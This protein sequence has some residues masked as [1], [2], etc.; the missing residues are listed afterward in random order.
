MQ[1]IAAFL[2]QRCTKQP[3]SKYLLAHFVEDFVYGF[4]PPDQ[5]DAW[6]KPKIIRALEALGI[7]RGRTST[8]QIA[9]ANLTPLPRFQ[10]VVRDGKLRKEPIGSNI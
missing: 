9:L 5:R 1:T 8:G 2:D 10:Y 7:E 4:L 3:G 6:S